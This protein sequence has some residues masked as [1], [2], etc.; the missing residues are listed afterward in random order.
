MPNAHRA[1]LN[2]GELLGYLTTKEFK[3]VC[4][5]VAL[6]WLAACMIHDEKKYIQRIKNIVKQGDSLLETIVNRGIKAR[7]DGA[8][9]CLSYRHN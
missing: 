5:G 9:L 3:G 6:T 4:H 8:A 2:R 1:L 7:I